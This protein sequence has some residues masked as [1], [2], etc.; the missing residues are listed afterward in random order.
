M[1]ALCYCT[2]R[3]F[4]SRHSP[5]F[6]SCSLNP[7]PF[8]GNIFMIYHYWCCVSHLLSY[9]IADA[10]DEL[11]EYLNSWLR[12]FIT[13]ASIS[14]VVLFYQILM[15][16]EWVFENFFSPSRGLLG[17]PKALCSISGWPKWVHKPKWL[18]GRNGLKGWQILTWLFGDICSK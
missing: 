8:K 17:C 14:T 11:W 9:P 12:C 1:N 4:N 10:D 15:A 6:Y 7:W 16:N 3:G 13:D 5:Y 18:T 2:M